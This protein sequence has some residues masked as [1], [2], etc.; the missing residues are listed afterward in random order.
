MSE[1]RVRKTWIDSITAVFAPDSTM[2]RMVSRARLEWTARH[3]DAAQTGRRTS[4]W[5][6]NTSDV[7]ATVARSAL[8]LRLHARDLIRNS[9]WARRGV[10]VIANNTVGWGITPKPLVESGQA[11]KLSAAWKAWAESTRCDRDGRLTFAGMQRQVMTSVAES[12]DVFVRRWPLKGAP[13]PFQLQ[14]LEADYLD[15]SRSDDKT[16]YGIEFAADGSRAAYWLYSAHPGSGVSGIVSKRVP[17]E[18]ILH[19]FRTERPG[20]TRGVSWFGPVIAALK[21]FDEYE[22]ATLMKQKVASMLAGVV[23]GVGDGSAMG[24][25]SAADPLIETWSPGQMLYLQDGTAVTFSNPPAV[26]EHDSYSKTNLRKICAGLGISVEELTGDYSQVNFSS[27][28]MS[29]LAHYANVKDWRWNM[30]IPIF[31]DGVWN[32]FTAFASGVAVPVEWTAP[33]MPMIEP[34]KEG[35]AYQRLI[36][37]GAMTPSDMVREQGGDPDVHWPAYAADLKNLDTLGIKLDSDVRAV[38]QAGQNQ[39]EAAEPEPVTAE[40]A[41][42]A[43]A[44]RKLDALIADYARSQLVP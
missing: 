13:V 3:Y 26:N 7:N 34:D 10:N 35:L 12:G 19:V 21:D 44:G 23:T 42:E 16:T 43:E 20:Q 32:W 30:L 31:C 25:Q 8:E 14:L 29:R 38:S 33:P 17:A 18:D 36:R 9:A 4:G 15:T 22:D 27:A 40:E 37:V 2:K 24:A 39:V 41:A 6:R 28:R 1:F 5:N 11:A